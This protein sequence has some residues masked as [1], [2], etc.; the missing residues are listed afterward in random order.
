ML[1]VTMQIYQQCVQ[2][3]ACVCVRIS[4]LVF[5]KTEGKKMFYLLPNS[6]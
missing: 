2:Q 5:C 3:R 1:L 4:Y 6:M